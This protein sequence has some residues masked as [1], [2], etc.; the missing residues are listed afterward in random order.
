MRRG[1]G[2]EVRTTV[3]VLGLLALVII[4]AVVWRAGTK[5]QQQYEDE[6]EVE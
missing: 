4:L 5:L 3:T 1:K 6:Q 2:D